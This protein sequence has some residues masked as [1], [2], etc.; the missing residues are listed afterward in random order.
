M[1][2]DHGIGQGKTNADIDRHWW[3]LCLHGRFRRV[4]RLI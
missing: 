3:G 4:S 2:Y 1:E